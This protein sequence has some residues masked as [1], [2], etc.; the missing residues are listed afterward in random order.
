MTQQP[1]YKAELR[2]T[3]TMHELENTKRHFYT[4]TAGVFS[5]VALAIIF[6]YLTVMSYLVVGIAGPIFISVLFLVALLF[7]FFYQLTKDLLERARAPKEKPV[8][9]QEST[10]ES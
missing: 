6:M 10:Q 4:G 1:D 7:P 2:A 9:G 3:Y 8:V 5:R